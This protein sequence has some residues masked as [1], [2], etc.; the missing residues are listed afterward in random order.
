MILCLI[1]LNPCGKNG[2]MNYVICRTL[3]CQ[4]VYKPE[5]FGEMK[6]VEL[7]HFS[8][9][10]QDGYGQ[11]SYIRFVNVN[12]EIHCSLVMSKSRVTPLRAVTI[13]RLELTAAVVSSKVSVMLR[14]ELDYQNIKEIFWTDSKAILG[15]ISNDAKRFHVFVANRVQYIRDRTD[16]I[17][18]NYVQ[19][20]SNPADCAARGLCVKELMDNLMWWNGPKFLWK[21]LDYCGSSCEQRSIFED[22]PEVKKVSFV[23]T[24]KKEESFL[25]RLDYFSD[26][27]RAK[28]AT[29]LCLSLQSK[30]KKT[31]ETS[32]EKIDKRNVTYSPV[33]VSEL[34]KAEKVIIKELQSKYYADEKRVLQT[35][36]VLNKRS[37]LYKLDPFMDIDGIMKVQGR[38]SQANLNEA[39]RHPVILPGRCHYHH[40]GRGIT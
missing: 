35:K 11:C 12:D 17:Q 5:G 25:D 28:R 31:T 38:L 4:D 15:Y 29:A 36:K 14:K 22:D 20:E 39:S 8:D 27:F 21:K 19:S 32:E 1:I 37:C 34:E 9:A 33:T 40:Q 7:H 13:P 24:S 2:E 26:W 6:S 18:W 30:N 3:S 23:V 10:C 16:P